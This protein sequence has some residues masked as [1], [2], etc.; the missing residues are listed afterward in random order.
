MRLWRSTSY[1]LTTLPRQLPPDTAG[2]DNDD[3]DDDDDGMDNSRDTSSDWVSRFIDIDCNRSIQEIRDLFSQCGEIRS[4][5]PWKSDKN[6]QQHYFLEFAHKSSVAN[7]RALG[8]LHHHLSVHALSMVPQLIERCR[9]MAP[10]S[11]EDPIDSFYASSRPSSPVSS[12]ESSVGPARKRTRRGGVKHKIRMG[13]KVTHGAGHSRLDGSL[14]PSNAHKTDTTAPVES[15]RPEDDKENDANRTRPTSSVLPHPLISP[16]IPIHLTHPLPPTP[17]SPHSPSAH[18]TLALHGERIS[19]DLNTL[20]NDP[21]PVVA[22]LQTAQCGRESWMI[23][24]GHYRMRGNP[25][26]ALVVTTAM[27]D[28]LTSAGVPERE[29]KPAYLMLSGCHRDLAQRAAQGSDEAAGH[30]AEAVRWLQKV[31]GRD[32]PPLDPPVCRPTRT[33][34][35]RIRILEREIACLRARLDGA[36]QLEDEVARRDREVEELRG[37]LEAA[38]RM[39][40]LAM[41]RV[42]REV[43]AR[44]QAEEGGLVR[45]VV[46]VLRRAARGEEAAVV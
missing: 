36:R 8:K 31:Y 20:N 43:E 39:E 18:I 25:A 40:G 16:T 3:D 38:R 37:K 41:E 11:I 17:S 42:R 1:I 7:A 34:P 33:S 12:H 29:L 10:R 26:A 14:P 24:G 2:A 19:L 4:I 46:E 27:I 28:V 13:N 30:L 44:R 45:E 32:A 15:R 35:G 23:V 22:L 9:S 6:P 21:H 5:Y